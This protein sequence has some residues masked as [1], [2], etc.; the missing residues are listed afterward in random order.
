MARKYTSISIQTTLASAISSSA[1]SITVANAA[2]LIGEVTF[3]GGNVDQ[4]AL[5]IDPETVNE[6]IVFVTDANTVT[7]VLTVVRARAGTTNIAHNSGATVKHVLTGEDLTYFEAGVTG[8]VTAASTTTL[9]NKTV[10]LSSN[11]LTGTVAQFN[12][13]LSNGDFATIAG[14]ETLTNKTLTAPVISTISNTG[15]ITLP[16]ATDTLVGRATTDTLTNKTLTAPVVNLS[17][18]SQTTA[19]TLVS[20]DKSKVVVI[21][22]S[23]TANVTLN[24]GT[25][26]QGDVVYIIRNG[27]GACSVTAGGGVTLNGT[28]GLALRAQ[29]SSAAIICTGS[30]TFV[31]V[32]DLSA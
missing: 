11:T 14:A 22:S 5:A 31:L 9:T 16:T 4:F 20:G 23:G 24:T 29:Y 12:T 25:F 26:V 3:A 18:N 13:A 21:T 19:Y 6:E 1:T 27:S 8:A 10:N 28:P 32:G 17:I 2:N 30:E 7:N 15:T